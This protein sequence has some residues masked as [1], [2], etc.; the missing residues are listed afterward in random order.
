MI[1]NFFLDNR[2]G[3]PHNYSK[4]IENISNQKYLNVTS[5]KSKF[6]KTYITNLRNFS[7]YLFIFEIVLNFFEILILFKN[8]KYKYFYVFSILN[9]APIIS[10]IFLRKKIKWFIVEEPNFF[11]KY[12]F[13]IL[14]LIGNFETVVISKFIANI[15]KIKKFKIIYP[16]IDTKFWKNINS[17]DYKKK[18]LK[19][20]CVGNLNKTKNY[21]NLLKYL[22]NVNILFEIKIVGE[23]LKTQKNYIEKIQVIKENINKNTSNKVILLGRLNK[24]KIKYLLKNTD[25]FILPSLT[26]GLSLS[27]MEAM[28][29]GSLCLI[30]SDSNKSKLVNDNKNG[31]IFK[32]SQDSFSKSLMKII[33]LNKKKKIDIKNKARVTIIKFNQKN[34]I[35]NKKRSIS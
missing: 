11:S 10:G 28:S 29:M 9:F 17:S 7:R 15:L 32:L 31:F 23:I 19:I 25:L 35:N 12:I 22:Q 24:N 16:Y 5:G 3:G 30:S 4:N 6:C 20:L 13:R 18:Y 27:L 26:E 21:L 34:K 33:N 8:K 2:V 14:N 1:I